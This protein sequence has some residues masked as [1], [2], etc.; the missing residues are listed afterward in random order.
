MWFIVECLVSL[1]LFPNNPNPEERHIQVNWE[2]PDFHA[3]CWSILGSLYLL[4][5]KVTSLDQSLNW[6]P[7]QPPKY[8]WNYLQMSFLSSF[9]LK[10][11][12]VS[13]RTNTF[14]LHIIEG[15]QLKIWFCSC[16]SINHSFSQSVDLKFSSLIEYFQS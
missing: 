2:T 5:Q 4:L 10:S 8:Q 16:I 13:I 3:S 9:S 15:I 12:T 6:Q 1:M 14:K 7:W 11:R